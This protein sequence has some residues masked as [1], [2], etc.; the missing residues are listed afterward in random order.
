MLDECI[1]KWAGFL[2][3]IQQLNKVVEQLT[4]S[5]NEVLHFQ[6]T[7]TEKRTQLDK[8]KVNII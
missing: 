1:Q 2:E 6:T 4:S 5:Y 7:F 3:Q 8:I